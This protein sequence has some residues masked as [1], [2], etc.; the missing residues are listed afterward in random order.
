MK[1][2]KRCSKCGRF[3]KYTGKQCDKCSAKDFKK[4]PLVTFRYPNAE[5]VLGDSIRV[6]RVVRMDSRYIQGF[7]EMDNDHFKKFCVYRV[8]S[9]VNLVEFLSAGE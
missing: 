2:N 6:I 8:R 4:L 5:D 9:A 3:K 1:Y 7:D